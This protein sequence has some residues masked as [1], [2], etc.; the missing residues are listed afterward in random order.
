MKKYVSIDIGG[1]KI[2]YGIIGENGEILCKDSMETGAEKGGKEILKKVIAL[3]K[4]Y[5]DNNAISGICL[6]SAG[7]IDP[8]KGEVFYASPLIPDYTGMRW[9][10]VLEEAFHIPC[11]VENDVNCMGLAEGVSGAA[12]GSK[13][14]LCLT[15]GTGIG[16][17]ILIDGNV[18]HGCSNSACEIG[19]LPMG[20]YNFETLGSS[21][22]LCKKVTERK[23]D[24]TVW[25]GCQIFQAAEKGDEICIAAIEEMAHVLGKGIATISYVINPD[26]VVLGGGIA[27]QEVYLKPLIEKYLKQYLIQSMEDRISFRFAQ[28]KNSAGMLGAFYHFMQ[29]QCQ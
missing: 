12:M 26:T 11:E 15:V 6:S 21:R 27:K 23:N 8:D 17:C 4:M 24:K 20:E 5:R 13:V 22:A 2:K 10:K 7:M 28:H 18:F 9:K 16:G 3:V 14:A 19:Y 29:K 1:T 25:N